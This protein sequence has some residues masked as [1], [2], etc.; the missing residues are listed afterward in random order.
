MPADL[1]GEQRLIAGATNHA[2]YPDEDR[3]FVDFFANQ[4][5]ELSFSGPHDNIVFSVTARVERFAQMPRFD[6]SLTR[7]ALPEA[8]AR[9][10][11]LG[12]DAPHHF[13]GASLLAGPEKETTAFS[14]AQIA[15]GM[16][17][18]AAVIAIGEAL[19][20]TLT[21]AEGATTVDTPML[22]A[23][24]KKS[25]VCQDFSHIM[26]SCLRGVGIPAGYVSGFLRTLPP[27]G[28]ER[29]EG[30]DAMHA[31]VRAWCGPD[32]GWIE[33]DPT[34][35]VLVG[36]DHIVVARGRDYFDV[37]PVKGIMRSYGAHSTTQAVD[38]V[39]V[40]ER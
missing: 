17:V 28:Q 18:Y 3:H 23:F 8:L 38:V 21:Y 14:L 29:L 22:E 27:E 12:P 7:E 32:M 31:W 11:D 5:A 10:T 4:A 6:T 30:A 33:Y 24:R 35:A 20:A 2:P 26:I 40:G 1:P 34:N 9:I 19:H 37:T 13:T 36:P 15:P 39:P 16:S 25:G